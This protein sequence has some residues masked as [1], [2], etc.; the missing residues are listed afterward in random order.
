MCAAAT[1]CPPKSPPAA[2][3]R[4]RI[5]PRAPRPERAPPDAYAAVPYRDRWF[6]IDAGD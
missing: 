3:P 6:W 5:H 1:P 4:E 2:D